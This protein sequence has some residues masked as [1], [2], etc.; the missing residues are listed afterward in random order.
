MVW[1]PRSRCHWCSGVICTGSMRCPAR[2]PRVTGAMG[3]REVVLPVACTL[4]RLARAQRW[5]LLSPHIL[6]WHGPMEMV[7]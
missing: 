4:R 5:T 2:A 1:A 7:L 3:G 6:P